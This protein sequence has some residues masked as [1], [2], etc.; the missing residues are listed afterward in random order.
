MDKSKEIITSNALLSQNMQEPFL[1]TGNVRKAFLQI[2]FHATM[3]K[4][5]HFK[6]ETWGKIYFKFSFKLKLVKSLL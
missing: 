5:C 4:N 3:D 6:W 1:Y 2:H